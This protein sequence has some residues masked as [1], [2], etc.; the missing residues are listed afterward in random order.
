MRA[1]GVECC[2]EGA[3]IGQAAQ[4]RLP[5]HGQ[6]ME[7]G[8]DAVGD[9]LTVNGGQRDFGWD[10]HPWARHQRLLESVAMDIDDAG[11][12][13]KPARVDAGGVGGRA[14]GEDPARDRHRGIGESAVHQRVATLDQP[15]HGSPPDNS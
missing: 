1:H 9:K 11:Q 3:G 2:N 8:G 4:T 15:V 13:I 12:H 7:G 10:R 5:R 14:V 6:A